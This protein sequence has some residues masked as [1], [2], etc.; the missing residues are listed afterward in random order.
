MPPAVAMMRLGY[1]VILSTF[2]ADPLL[3]ESACTVSTPAWSAMEADMQV[4][5]SSVSKTALLIA[6]WALYFM[7]I[8]SGTSLAR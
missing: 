1:F 7:P 4:R 6:S 2:T 3:A 5:P 8:E